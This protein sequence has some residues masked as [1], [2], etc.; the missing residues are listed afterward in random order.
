[1]LKAA[2]TASVFCATL[3]LVMSANSETGRGQ[4]CTPLAAMPGL[5]ASEL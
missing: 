5:M 2:P 1:M 4:S 3:F